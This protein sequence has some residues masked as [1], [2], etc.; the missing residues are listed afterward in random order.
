MSADCLN[1]LHD[2]GSY[3]LRFIMQ[4]VVKQC[5]QVMSHKAMAESL[6]ATVEFLE[7]LKRVSTLEDAMGGTGFTSRR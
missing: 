5:P 6:Q 2:S 4:F 1:L 7:G 3:G